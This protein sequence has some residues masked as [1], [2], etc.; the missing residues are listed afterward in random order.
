MIFVF[1]YNHYF[2]DHDCVHV[3]AFL[4]VYAPWFVKHLKKHLKKEVFKVGVYS[5]SC[6]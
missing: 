5:A 1:D 3:S 2:C 6:P 4:F